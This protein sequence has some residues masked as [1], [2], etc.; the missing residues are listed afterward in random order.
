MK[1]LRPLFIILV[2]LVLIV[3]LFFAL[4]KKENMVT[5]FE[6][7]VAKKPLHLALHHYQ[8][9]YCGMVIDELDYASQIVSPDGKTWFFH[10]HGDLV[11]WLEERTFKDKAVIWVHALDTNGWINGRKAFYT[12]DEETPMHYGFGAYA[13]PSKDRISFETMQKYTLRGETM[14]NPRIRKQ[15]LAKKEKF[16]NH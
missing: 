4:A 5:I 2:I 11:K 6:G 9:A 1:S 3:T 8:D 16:G 12:R 7:N 13:K 15:L 10:D 14:L